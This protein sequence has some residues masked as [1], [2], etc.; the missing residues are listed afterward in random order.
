MDMWNL[1]PFVGGTTNENSQ[2]LS[3]SFLS[4]TLP[5]IIT[6]PPGAFDPPAAGQYSFALIALRDGVEVARSAIN[7]QVPEPGPLA[8]LGMAGLRA[9]RR[10]KQAK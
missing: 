8:L 3:F 9:A 6:P 1:T 4:A 2:N 10:R 7:V 5:G